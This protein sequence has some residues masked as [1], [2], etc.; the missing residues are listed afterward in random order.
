MTG[1]QINTNQQKLITNLDSRIFIGKK[2]YSPIDFSSLAAMIVAL[3]DAGYFCGCFDTILFPE[4]SGE[5]WT[6]CIQFQRS[7]DANVIVVLAY[8]IY[9]KVIYQNYLTGENTWYFADWK[10]FE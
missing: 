7:Y 1:R 2:R 6:Y 5:K 4:F 10:R 8:K 9:S 3:R